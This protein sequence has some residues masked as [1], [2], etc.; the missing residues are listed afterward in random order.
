MLNVMGDGYYG[1]GNMLGKHNELC[2]LVTGTLSRKLK[3]NTWDL[4][5]EAR[6]ALL[7]YEK[8]GKQNQSSTKRRTKL[9]RG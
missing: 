1:G 8:N 7:L 2:V 5:D 9:K 3:H 6:Y 4:N